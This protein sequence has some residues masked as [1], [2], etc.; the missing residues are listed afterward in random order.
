M[1][2]SIQ[3]A[4]RLQGPGRVRSHLCCRAAA[5]L[6]TEMGLRARLQDGSHL[7]LDFL[8]TPMQQSSPTAMAFVNQIHQPAST[9]HL[10]PPIPG[11][12]PANYTYAPVDQQVSKAGLLSPQIHEVHEKQARSTLRWKLRKL[13][14]DFW[15]WEAAACIIA[16]AIAA[17]I[18]Q[19][20][21]ALDGNSTANWTQSWSPT[22]ALAL[23]VTIAKAA[24][25]VPVAS[26]I[27]QLKWH[28]YK[29]T[30]KLDKLETF[31]GASR[32]VLGSLKLLWEMK[33][34]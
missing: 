3:S 21:K 4:G 14:S 6:T 9:F 20:L 17:V 29:K 19:Q 11:T 7:C 31:D 28:N 34:W 26:A 32:G 24:M 23:A 8:H 12:E 25:L 22:S 27:S 1:Q 13:L 15:V 16:L 2:G 10:G 5:R 30:Q 33:C 18:G